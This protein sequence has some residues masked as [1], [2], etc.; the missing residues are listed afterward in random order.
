MVIL[1]AVKI[2]SN[3]KSA[4][5][6]TNKSATSDIKSVLLLFSHYFGV[7]CYQSYIYK[8]SIS[9]SLVQS[10]FLCYTCL[11][12]SDEADV[13][14]CFGTLIIIQ[15]LSAV[16]VGVAR[17]PRETCQLFFAHRLSDLLSH[18]QLEAFSATSLISFTALVLSFPVNPICLRARIVDVLTNPRH[19]TSTG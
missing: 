17:S 9:V 12:L 18:N 8:Y 10:I 6:E 13:L 5:H 2:S 3:T 7:S 4:Q 19:P 16:P 14:D 11:V 15:S 1:Y